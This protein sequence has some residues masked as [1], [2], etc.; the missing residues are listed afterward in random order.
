[1]KSLKTLLRIARRELETLRRSLARQ[2][3]K[4]T[5]IEQGIATLAQCIADEQKNALGDFEATRAYGAF[6]VHA[7]ARRRALKSELA[8]AEEIGDR[9]R[10][11]IGEAHVEM[12]KFERLIELQEERDRVAA[13]KREAA[14]LDELA[15]QRAGRMRAL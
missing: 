9:L 6:A 15:T 3:A 10:V 7:V 8:A 14:E 1:M 12:R 5:S 11:L 2:I 13:A 4:Q